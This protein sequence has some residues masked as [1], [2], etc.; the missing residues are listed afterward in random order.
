MNNRSVFLSTKQLAVI[1]LAAALLSLLFSS[2]SSSPLG[3]FLVW[4]ILIFSFIS[5]FVLIIKLMA[6][7]A[8]SISSGSKISNRRNSY[9]DDSDAINH[10]MYKYEQDS[11]DD[12]CDSGSS[13]SGG[14]CD[15][16]S[17]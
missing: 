16:S 8:N 3:S 17:D 7:G 14:N 12:R 9:R 11:H 1:I 4:I 5:I 15:S 10:E 13:D 2:S 6:R